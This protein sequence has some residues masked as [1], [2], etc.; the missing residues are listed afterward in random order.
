MLASNVARFSRKLAGKHGAVPD[1]FHPRRLETRMSMRPVTNLN[2]RR[3]LAARV[4]IG[5]YYTDGVRL[6]E[7]ESIGATGCVIFRD[8]CTGW[9]RCLSIEDFRAGFWLV[10]GSEEAA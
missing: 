3:R 9:D 4:L 6:Y 2:D 8:C 7:A 5:A 1:P 10:K